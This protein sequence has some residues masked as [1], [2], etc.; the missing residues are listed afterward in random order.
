MV[1]L[2]PAGRID[3][4]TAD[5][6]QAALMPYVDRCVGAEGRIVL[7]LADVP[8]M[9]SVGLRVLILAA[10]QSKK[11]QGTIVV[12]GLPSTL[13]EIFEISRFT[14]IF[15]TYASLREALGALSATALAAH[16]RG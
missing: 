2:A 8:Y 1:V 7:D 4:N 9:S 13:R 10:K 11:Q 16:E 14:Q 12:A 6:F 15:Q 5:A 3:H